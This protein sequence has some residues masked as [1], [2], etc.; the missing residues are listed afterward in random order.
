MSFFLFSS[1]WVLLDAV[2]RWRP[3][4]SRFRGKGRARL[5]VRGLGGGTELQSAVRIGVVGRPASR[6]EAGSLEGAGGALASRS[7]QGD[8]VNTGGGRG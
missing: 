3:A 5:A 4:Q 8:W 6:G 2:H 1:P 7:L